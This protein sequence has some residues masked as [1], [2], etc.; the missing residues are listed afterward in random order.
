MNEPELALC[1]TATDDAP[2]LSCEG[3]HLNY[4]QLRRRAGAIAA[5]L[6]ALGMKRGERFAFLLVNGPNLLAS[7]MACAQTGIVGVPLSQRLTS[8]ELAFQIADAD[9]LALLSSP[10]FA[11]LIGQVAGRL[12]GVRLWFTEP[13][14]DNTGPA[15]DVVAAD[16]PLASVDPFCIMYTGGTTGRAKAAVQT[17]A[18]WACCL[19]ATV[20]A[21]QGTAA[22]RHLISL[23]MSHAA[24]F[25]A[26]ATLRAG[27][28]VTILRSWN[29]ARALEVIEQERIST[30]NM[31]PTMLGDLVKAYEQQPRA[32]SSVRLLTVAGSLLPAAT[33]ERACAILGPVVGNIYGLTEAAGP[34]TFLM[35]SDMQGDLRHSVGRPN[36]FIELVILDDE[37]RPT[38]GCEPGEI[39]LA[40]P[41][42]TPAYWRRPDETRDAYAGRFLRT[43]D[44]ARVD[45]E[46]FVHLTDRKKDMI[47]SGGYNVYPSEVEQVI[48]AHPAVLECA[49]LGAPDEHWIEAVHAVVVLR[50]DH[51]ACLAEDIVAACRREL[52][53]HKVPKA[54]HLVEQIPRTRFG[55]FDRA[56][57]LCLIT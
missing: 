22:D 34:V 15:L 7:Y 18:G 33:Y 38:D 25:S 30:L 21:W 2:A 6:Q 56:A 51:A 41:Q 50:P 14:I 13:E 19:Q 20:D 39:G 10:D 12:P 9:V 16:G 11:P 36:R 44:V 23:P 57:T 27:G 35:P 5:Q 55:K 54:I 8:A 46:G 48:Y 1:F 40:G 24:W 53:G 42:V 49:V 32:I 3:E 17:R 4:G 26:G 45:K 52:A 47:K 29:A 31:I 43:G 28:H 37:G